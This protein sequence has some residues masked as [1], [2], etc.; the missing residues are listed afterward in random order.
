MV[1]KRH[2]ENQPQKLSSWPADHL[3]GGH[4]DSFRR[5]V[6]LYSRAAR[7]CIGQ[8]ALTCDGQLP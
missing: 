6:C 1:L 7:T 8:T 4:E 2:S 3:G 5:G